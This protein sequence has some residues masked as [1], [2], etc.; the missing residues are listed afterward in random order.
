MKKNSKTD[1]TYNRDIISEE[2]MEEKEKIDFISL[3]ENDDIKLFINIYNAY[4]K[5]KDKYKKLDFSKLKYLEL[6]HNKN[7]ENLI[8]INEDDDVKKIIRLVENNKKIVI[9]LDNVTAGKYYNTKMKNK[10]DE[11]IK[12]FE[13]YTL[14]QIKENP[15][16]IV[17][18]I[19]L[20]K[21]DNE[22]SNSNDK[23]IIDKIIKK[24]IF[25][26]I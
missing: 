8:N 1:I 21:Y 5:E 12:K 9:D 10:I 17:R 11:M 24:W 26:S 2:T 14:E 4:I 3:I 13:R 18:D 6:T 22:L 25:Y 15:E 7:E 16:D 19:I 20:A 23:I